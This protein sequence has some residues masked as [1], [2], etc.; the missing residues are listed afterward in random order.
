MDEKATTAPVQAAGEGVDEGAGAP[1]R[2][3]RPDSQGKVRDLYDLGDEL[4]LV[5]SDRISAFDFIL[6]DEIP[7][8]G[9]V[10]TQLSLFWLG[11]FADRVDNHLVSADTADLPERFAP[12]ADYLAGRFMLVKK[13]QMFPVECIVRGYLT[14]SGLASYKRDGRVCGI[15]LAPG[16]EEASELP[17]P[18]FTPSTKAAIGGHDENI[19]F[20]QL[21]DLV[22]ADDARMLRDVSLDL[23]RAAARYAKE[24]GIIVA[25][26]K[27][28][29]GM[30]DGRLV[31]ADEVL[32]PDSSRFWPVEGYAPGR[33]QPSF[34]K[35]Y[36]RDWL[37]GAW[38]RTGTPPHM[39]EEVKQASAANYAQAYEMLTGRPFTAQSR[40]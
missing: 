2:A 12:Y 18:L 24:R 6:P 26:T 14:G 22:G 10:L 3:L 11:F 37:S 32:T 16:L 21:E 9:E 31:L 4:L 40:V 38:D 29:F 15:E 7:H 34:D 27:F 28:E 35:Q 8:K 19:S 1:K 30:V 5:A 23:Y 20:A 36:V 39:P 13:A 33:V 25:D 17:E